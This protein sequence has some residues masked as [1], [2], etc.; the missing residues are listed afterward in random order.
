MFRPHRLASLDH[1]IYTDASGSFGCSAVWCQG[2]P[3]AP[4]ELVPIV[5]ACVIWGQAWQGQV[6]HVHLD[7]KAVVAVIVQ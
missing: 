4:K 2:V 1:E 7:N 5:M 6:V 3:I